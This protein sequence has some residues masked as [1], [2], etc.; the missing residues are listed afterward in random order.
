[1]ALGSAL[2]A[3]LALGGLG[4]VLGAALALFHRVFYVYEDPRIEQVEEL[5]PGGNC[6]A[7]G[8]A[9]CHAFAEAVVAGGIAPSACTAVSPET[10]EAIAELLGVDAGESE[11][12]VARLACAGGRHVARMRALYEGMESCRAAAVAGGGG[13][14]CA[15]GCLGLG[16]CLAACDFGAIT[17]DEN[18]LPVVDEAK[19]TACN[20]CVEVC[21]RNLFSIHPVSH[22]LWVACSNEDEGERAE[23][24]C[25]VACTACGKCAA[26]APQELITVTDNLARV[27]YSKNALAT[28][29]VIQRC[30]TGAI[31]WYGAAGG[32]EKGA[33]AKRIVRREPLPLAGDTEG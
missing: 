16:D 5:L 1:M 6:G 18:G 31:V 15:W 2:T 11:K 27:D 17:M 26:D 3:A 23:A 25:E 24:D 13:K 29:Q 10:T 28:R 19:C 32:P 21:P 9:G 20:R 22:R 14:G 33:E 7:C 4:L 8:N 12:R 30:P